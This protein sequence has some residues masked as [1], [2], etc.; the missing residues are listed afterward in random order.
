MKNP[1]V[2]KKFKLDELRGVN[3][4]NCGATIDDILDSLINQKYLVNLN[5]DG[6]AADDASVKRLNRMHLERLNV[7]NTGITGGGLATATRLLPN[8]KALA[9]E[10]MTN[11]TV[12]LRKLVATAHK[13]EHLYICNSNLGTSDLIEIGKIKS[14]TSLDLTNN[15]GVND[16]TIKPLAELPNL[17]DIDFENCR[18]SPK[19]LETLNKMPR[20]RTVHISAPS[21]TAEQ[22][23]D[24]RAKYK[25]GNV[26]F[27]DSIVKELKNI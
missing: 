17:R 7:R 19:C 2:F 15:I 6:S 9:V 3:L 5:I 24:F 25:G 14:L 13:I 18:L 8:L 22:Q 26:D 23:D 21:W 20:V 11:P 1:L 16:E 10:Q 12:I 4:K 27:K